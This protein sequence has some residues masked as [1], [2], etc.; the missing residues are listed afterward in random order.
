[1]VPVPTNVAPV[2]GRGRYRSTVSKDGRHD[3][4]HLKVIAKV[5]LCS[6]VHVVVPK[7]LAPKV[8]F[9]G[10]YPQCPITL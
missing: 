10:A 5:S 8:S 7:A 1:M 9:V 3:V 2:R 4:M 6:Q